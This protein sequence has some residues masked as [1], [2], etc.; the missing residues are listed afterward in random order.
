MSSIQ[1]VRVTDQ[2]PVGIPSL[3]A[4]S[5][6]EGVRNLG[7]LMGDWRAGARFDGAGEALFTAF[8][9]GRLVGLGA[10]TPC[11]D[12]PGAER[13]RRFYVSPAHRRSGVGQ[14]LAAAA[15]QE[16]LQHAR[17][18]TCNARASPAAAP[19]WESMGFKAASAAGYTHLFEG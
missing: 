1:L 19:F 10:V 3:V 6:A 7:L 13:M 14:V 17:V 16:G 11:T 18:L 8:V 5:S 9:D 15:M 12:L 2:L 4:D